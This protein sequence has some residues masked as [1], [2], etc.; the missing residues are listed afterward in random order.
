MTEVA[1][2]IIRRQDGR[3]LIC[4]RGEGRSN[5]HLWEFPGGKL[6][7]GESPCECLKRE[8][9]EELRLPVERLREVCQREAQGIL[10]HF[11][12]GAA[13]AEPVLTE[14]EA[15]AF[16]TD[17]EMLGYAFCPADTAVARAMALNAPALRHFFWDFD[18]TV[19]D[20]Y[21]A[22]TEAF[23][24]MAVRFGVEITHERALSLLKNNLTHA[25]NV[26][27]GENGLDAAGMVPVYREEERETLLRMARP[28]AGIPEALRELPGRHYLVTHRNRAALDYLDSMGL[29]GFFTDFVVEDDGFPRKPAPDSL[30]HLLRRHGLD[31]A[32]CV[33][34]GDRPLD[35]AAGRNAGMLSCLLDE[36][37]R[38]PEDPCELR[39]DSAWEL[40]GM[41]CPHM[42][43]ML[44]PHKG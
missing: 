35:T 30:L 29:K 31:P 5:A 22:M 14:H 36:E 7:A 6:E 1:A 34:I 8:L 39:V 4:Q 25:L 38:F 37:H 2:G 20:T 43:G 41:V 33:M 18:G 15:F 32:E 24:R 40:P 42:P 19:M 17:R 3:V 44:C 11:I 9:L 26:I 12:E 21:P 27:A 13:E 10:F 16:V 28:V 23:V